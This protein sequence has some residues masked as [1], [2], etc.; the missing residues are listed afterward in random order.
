MSVSGELELDSEQL[1]GGLVLVQPCGMPSRRCLSLS[2]IVPFSLGLRL[3]LLFFFLLFVPVVAAFL[4]GLL[5][6]Q[7]NYVTLSI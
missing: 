3:F 2:L 7:T 1:L 5:H 6:N 4:G